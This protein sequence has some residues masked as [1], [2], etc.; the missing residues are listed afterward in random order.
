MK[1]FKFS[2]VVALLSVVAYSCSKDEKEEEKGIYYPEDGLVSFFKFENNLSDELGNTPDGVNSNNAPFIEGVDGEAISFNGIDQKV[3][4]DRKTYRDGN[5]FSI[6][7]W[8]KKSDTTGNLYAIECSDFIFATNKDD[9]ILNI[10]FLS[11][12]NEN[13]RG[14]FTYGEW[15]HFTGTYDGTDIKA[16]INGELKETKSQI[17]TIDNTGRDLALAFRFSN[18][19][20]WK[21]SFDEL[22]IY[23][24]ILTASEVKDMY[25]R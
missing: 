15:T 5:S 3:I 19:T 22:F 8:F 17:G 21:G 16:Y 12:P 24:R 4:F 2:L 11:M 14:K 25:N 13:A 6:S 18:S 23:N 1:L 7:F 9:A 10:D 20:Y